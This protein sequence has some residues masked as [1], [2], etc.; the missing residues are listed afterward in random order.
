[1]S[2]LM[3]T[4]NSSADH[5]VVLQTQNKAVLSLSV[6]ARP[7]RQPHPAHCMPCAL[8]RPEPHASATRFVKEPVSAA[9]HVS[10]TRSAGAAAVPAPGATLTASPVPSQA[11]D[12][13]A[14]PFP[15]VY[16]AAHFA[17]HPCG[18]QPTFAL[19]GWPVKRFTPPS[20]FG[21]FMPRTVLQHF[22]ASTLASLGAADQAQ[23]TP[24]RT[25]GDCTQTDVLQTCVC[26]LPAVSDVDVATA[27]DDGMPAMAASGAVDADAGDSDDE[28]NAADAADTGVAHVPIVNEKTLLRSLGV[29]MH[30]GLHRLPRLCWHWTIS[31]RH[32]ATYGQCGC[33]T[34]LPR[35]VYM[36]HRRHITCTPAF[37]AD[38]MSS[39]WSAR[40]GVPVGIGVWTRPSS[41]FVASFSTVRTFPGSLIPRVCSTTSCLTRGCCN[42]LNSP[43]LRPVLASRSYSDCFVPVRVRPVTCC[44]RARRGECQHFLR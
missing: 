19:S 15:P 18:L 42:G 13:D 43:R 44:T 10:D 3:S 4:S 14:V 21:A 16:P 35:D 32:C 20:L 40:C 31:R 9:S 39:A 41:G 30:T 38:E 24:R 17:K 23:P 12:R 2:L 27:D 26:S 28:A 22:L 1:M 8:A 33:S 5:D 7:R 11:A 37:V 6:D 25:R 36:Y 29:T 34:W